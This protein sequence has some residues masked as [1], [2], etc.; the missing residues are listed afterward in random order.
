MGEALPR[1]FLSAAAAAATLL[2]DTLQRSV[3][4]TPACVFSRFFFLV[5]DAVQRERESKREKWEPVF[6]LLR[7]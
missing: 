4:Y 1:S 2:H 6:L 3:M 7:N 5:P